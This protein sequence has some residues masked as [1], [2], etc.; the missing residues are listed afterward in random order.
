MGKQ[1]LM[2]FKIKKYFK[3]AI[4]VFLFP[5]VTELLSFMIILLMQIGRIFGTSIRIIMNL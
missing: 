2:S 4:Y 1:K 3:I 5:V